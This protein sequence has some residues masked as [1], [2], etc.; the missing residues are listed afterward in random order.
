MTIGRVHINLV[1]TDVLF[2]YAPPFYWGGE[3]IGSPLSERPVPYVQ[4]MV[5]VQYLLKHWCIGF[6]FHTQVYNHK[7]QVKFD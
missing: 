7:T 2:H 3:Y 6:I 4:R 1:L 5:S